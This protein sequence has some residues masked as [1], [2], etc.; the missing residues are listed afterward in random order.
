M[1]ETLW[2]IG[3][4]KFYTLG[5]WLGGWLESKWKGPPPGRQIFEP[6]VINNISGSY[7]NFPDIRVFA[8]DPI[9]GNRSSKVQKRVDR[10]SGAAYAQ[11]VRNKVGYTLGGNLIPGT[12]YVRNRILYPAV[13]T[14]SAYDFRNNKFSTSTLPADVIGQSTRLQLHCLDRVGD[15]GV[16]V[17]FGGTSYNKTGIVGNVSFLLLLPCH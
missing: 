4:G 7:F 16:L 11:S 3:D 17:A 10:L 2:N 14:I 9:T 6:Y 5:G 12:S 1:L 13:D 8:Y 15:S